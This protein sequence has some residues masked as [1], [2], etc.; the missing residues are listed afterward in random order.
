MY[1]RERKVKQDLIYIGIKKEDSLR[2]GAY[3]TS[4][5]L[6][7]RKGKKNFL[8]LKSNNK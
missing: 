3:S 8:L 5:Q 6:V 1:K 7:K 2:A 4:F